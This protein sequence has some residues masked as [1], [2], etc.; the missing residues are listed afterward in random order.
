MEL[1][2]IFIIFIFIFF[3]LFIIN[4]CYKNPVKNKSGEK[5]AINDV[6]NMKCYNDPLTLAKCHITKEM[7]C[8]DKN[9]SFMQCTNNFK[10][11][12]N[13]ADCLERSYYYSPGG[14][15]LSEK[16]IYKE[17]FPFAVKTPTESTSKPT[18]FPRVNIFRNKS[19]P[20]IM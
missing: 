13:I 2:A 18:I 20:M 6:R 7:P 8:P 4:Q 15:R 16:C 19:L 9:G 10:R 12:V 17:V 11:E 3:V 5:F 1:F 14:E